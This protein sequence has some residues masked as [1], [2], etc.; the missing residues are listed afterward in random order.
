MIPEKE[1]YKKDKIITFKR[2]QDI[3]TDE[4]KSIINKS[5]TCYSHFYKG[6]S[7]FWLNGNFTNINAIKIS[8]HNNILNYGFANISFSYGQK[9]YNVQTCY[10]IPND[11]LTKNKQ[12]FYRRSLI[13]EMLGKDGT[14]GK[15]LK[16]KIIMRILLE[17]YKK[18]MK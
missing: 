18:I 4:D 6:Y 12:D 2:I 17:N 1:I 7:N 14:F 5:N 13:E 15:S 10:F 16:I 8:E 11:E 3:L 9:K